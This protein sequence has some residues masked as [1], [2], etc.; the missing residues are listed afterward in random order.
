MNSENNYC[1]H[2][3]IGSAPDSILGRDRGKAAND[4]FSIL[5]NTVPFNEE[6]IHLVIHD[7]VHAAS[8]Y[9]SISILW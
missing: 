1:N 7:I 4:C 9:L 6:Y 5:C 2:V 3:F 8:K